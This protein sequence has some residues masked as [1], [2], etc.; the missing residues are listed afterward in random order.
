M[1]IPFA[2]ST[3]SLN[4]DHYHFTLIGTVVAILLLCAWCIWFFFAQVTFFESSQEAR[5]S[6]GETLVAR[7]PKDHLHRIARGQ[8]ALFRPDG[9][10]GRTP[11]YPALVLSVDRDT[12]SEWG[13]VTLR[14]RA[15]APEPNN[16]SGALT[17]R[18]EIE[19]ER[20]SPATI[21][22]RS[23]GFGSASPPLVVSPQAVR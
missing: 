19:V 10:A 20:I 3:R 1:A 18:V 12:P 6:D 17:G 9:S 11:V 8:H 2:R 4:A 22:M 5:G 15:R 21:V 13:E 23:A 16:P 7:F 14:L